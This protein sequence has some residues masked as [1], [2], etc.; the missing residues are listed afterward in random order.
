[1]NFI[2]VHVQVTMKLV[3]YLAPILALLL[4]TSNADAS[5][6]ASSSGPRRMLQ[7]PGSI[8]QINPWNL[9]IT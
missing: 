7:Q 1:M 8:H 4:A 9:G 6:S 3:V 2:P 5:S